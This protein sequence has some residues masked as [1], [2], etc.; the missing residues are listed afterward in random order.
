LKP[1]R[2]LR[3]LAKDLRGAEKTLVAPRGFYYTFDGFRINANDC[4]LLHDGRPVSMAPKVFDTLLALVENAGRVVHKEELMNAVWPDAFVEEANLTVNISSLRRVLGDACGQPRYIE[5]VARRGYRFVG[6]VKKWSDETAGQVPAEQKGSPA[7]TREETSGATVLAFTQETAGPRP[8]GGTA[9]ACPSRV[10][11]PAASLPRRIGRRRGIGLAVLAFSILLGAAAVGY[12][13]MRVARHAPP[14]TRSLAVLPFLNLRQDA[15]TDF[16]SVSLA[17]A[18]TTRLGYVSALI[19]RPS[20]DVYQ[21]RNQQV[22]PRLAGEQLKVDTLLMGHFFKD[23]GDLMITAQL[24]DVG[25]DEVLWQDEMRMKYEK[26]LDV[27]DHVVNQIIAGL[28]LNLL[29]AEAERL[30]SGTPTNPLAYEYY[31]RGITLYSTENVPIAIE[32]LEKS[33]SIDPGYA[34]AWAH[35]G[36]AYTANAS[37]HL[38]GRADYEKAEAA[39]QKSFE[40]DPDQ[41]EARSFMANMLTDTNRVEQAVP[42]LRDVLR[43]NPNYARAHWVLNYAYRFGGMLKE[44]IDEGEQA[45]RLDPGIT[46]IRATP[47]GYLYTGQYDKFIKSLPE[48]KDSA[49][50]VFYR[51]LG[52]YYLKDRVRAAADFDRAYELDDSMFHAQIGKALSYSLAGRTSQGLELISGTDHKVEQRGVSD[53]EAIYK[54]AQAYA[55]LGDRQSALRMLRRSIERGFFPYPYLLSDPL[56]DNIRNEPEYSTLMEMARDR[57]LRFKEVFFPG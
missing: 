51:G 29:P 40:L 19:V 27:Q 32:M 8:E 57:H 15:E 16:L 9:G 52:N 6:S 21:Y 50:Y 36:R 2:E 48:T 56:L 55:V 1:S 31:L 11:R 46:L 47:N 23:G 54:L 39:F 13:Q 43:A 49:F 4:L 37:L 22:T 41:F 42:L 25:S 30:M 14:G 18:I 7:T 34:L 35:L 20:S 44:S 45:R 17:D 12:K 28:R 26:L 3:G 5:T 38:G 24:I 53:A 33:I 10:M